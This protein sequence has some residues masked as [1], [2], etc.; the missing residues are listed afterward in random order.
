M[1]SG[2]FFDAPLPFKCTFTEIESK[3]KASILM[4]TICSSYNFSNQDCV[5]FTLRQSLPS[6]HR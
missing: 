5:V 3:L 6:P 4:R 1:V 2:R